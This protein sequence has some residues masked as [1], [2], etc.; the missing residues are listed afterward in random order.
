M[1]IKPVPIITADFGLLAE[2]LVQQGIDVTFIERLDQVMPSLDK[3]MA[4]H[5]EEYLKSKGIKLYLNETVTELGGDAKVKQVVLKDGKAI[6][7]DFV[8]MAVGIQPNA[9]LAKEAGL[10]LGVAGAIKVDKRMRTSN[11]DI[12]ACGDC[13]AAYSRITGKEIYR[14]L[15]TT[16]NKMGRIAGD[17]ITGGNMEFEGVLGTGIFKVFDLAVAQTGLTETAAIKEG[18]DTVVSYDKKIDRLE[19]Y[20]GKEMM[21]KAVADKNTGRLLGVQIIGYS[22]VDKRIDVF[23]SAI[24]FG[25]TVED[26]MNLDLAYSPP[27]STAKDPVIY[28][29]MILSNKIAMEKG[30]RS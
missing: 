6:D 21:I 3:D 13:A 17:Q 8:I 16:A 15:G 20:E 5:L 2:N 7:T 19:Y 4:V 18:F 26:L 28:T 11:K 27:F 1:P 29:G 14:P 10:E 22:G 23:A 30:F 12:Y 9:S 24:T 25:A